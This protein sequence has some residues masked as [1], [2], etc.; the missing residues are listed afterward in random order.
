[1]K[2]GTRPARMCFAEITPASV[3]LSSCFSASEMLLWNEC[4]VAPAGWEYSG[5]HRLWA[6]RRRLSIN[7]HLVPLTYLAK[8]AA[9]T[10]LN[11]DVSEWLCRRRVCA[12]E[13]FSWRFCYHGC[14]Y[15]NVQPIAWWN[16][17]QGIC[18]VLR[19]ASEYRI[20]GELVS[21]S[22]TISSELG[23]KEQWYSDGARVM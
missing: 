8:S 23:Q 16:G 22:E 15:E 11:V 18:W 9:V 21:H 7:F 5:T 12:V 4:L 6:R 17:D 13:F 3:Y 20:L 10:I 19:S 1:M 2:A 14:P